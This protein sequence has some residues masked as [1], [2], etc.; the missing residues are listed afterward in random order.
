[1]PAFVLDTAR[2]YPSAVRVPSLLS[3]IALLA[4]TAVAPSQAHAQQRAPRVLTVGLGGGG[5]V[6]VGDFANDVK[7]GWNGLAYLQYQPVGQGPW[8][9]RA[10]AQY[11]G[12]RYT[13]DFLFDVGATEDDDLSNS[14]LY[15]GVS[16][17]YHLGRPGA[18]ARPYLV[19]GLG[20][21]Q[22]TARLTDAGGVSVSDSESG[23]GFNG[24]AGMRF[25]G[26]IAIFVET[27][28]HQFSITPDGGEKST[29]QFIPVSIGITF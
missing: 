14:V 10:E 13:D 18:A 17:V 29:S 11:S 5:T 12:A 3:A 9:V 19:G 16:A 27:R 21:Y 23:F 4:L 26:P 28:F 24:G 8:A 22:L 25:G 20:L 2:H 6:P 15:A 1:V 7:T